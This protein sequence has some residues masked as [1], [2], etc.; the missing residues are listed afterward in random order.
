MRQASAHAAAPD[1]IPAPDRGRH[2]LCRVLRDLGRVQVYEDGGTHE[3]AAG[4][5]Y[6]M[7]YRMLAPLLA[8]GAVQ[9]I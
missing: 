1:M 6:V 2:V 8:Q 7:R 5:L 3:L 9:L 4:D